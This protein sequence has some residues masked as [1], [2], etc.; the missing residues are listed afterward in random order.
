MGYAV[1][2]NSAR[3]RTN[4]KNH[5]MKRI[6]LVMAIALVAAMQVSAQQKDSQLTP[7][8][9]TEQRIKQMDETLKLTDEQKTKIRSLYADF[10][11][12]KYPREKRREAMKKLTADISSL[13]TAEQQAAYKKM[14]R[15]SIAKNKDKKG[16]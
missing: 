8:Q 9:R 6:I 1:A 7:Q 12:Q 4:K 16:K 10:N 14:V 5:S 3:K 13:L 2:R 11:K 15:Q